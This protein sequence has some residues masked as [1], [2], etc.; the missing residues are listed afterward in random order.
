LVGQKECRLG[1]KINVWD[2]IKSAKSSNGF[3]SFKRKVKL[4]IKVSFLKAQK[5]RSLLMQRRNLISFQTLLICE[6]FHFKTNLCL[7]AS[8]PTQINYNY[9]KPFSSLFSWSLNFYNQNSLIWF[10]WTEFAFDLRELFR[11]KW[12]NLLN[13]LEIESF[14]SLHSS[15]VFIRIYWKL[16]CAQI[17]SEPTE[18]QIF[19]L[20]NSFL[21]KIRIV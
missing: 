5:I 21:L 16:R 15:K 2:V 3:K 10:E 17:K 11:I 19:S 1:I 12:T 20:S 18:T 4:W 14:Q 7:S 9:N 8:G 13:L 6:Q